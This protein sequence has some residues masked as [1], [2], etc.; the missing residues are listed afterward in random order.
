M[1]T[2]RV[3]TEEEDKPVT[4]ISKDMELSGIGSVIITRK[5]KPVGIV[6]DRDIALKICATGKAPGEVLAKEIMS[7]LSISIEPDAPLKK[8]C[9]LMADK[10]IRRLPVIDNGKLVGIISIRNVLTRAPDCVR[11]FYPAD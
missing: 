4:V 8:A 1:M 2:V 6:T 9:L 3:I 7:P 10:G 5:G 11:R